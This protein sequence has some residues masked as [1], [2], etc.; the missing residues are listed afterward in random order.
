[1]Y[2]MNEKLIVLAAL[3][4]RIEKDLFEAIVEGEL[5]AELKDWQEAK[6]KD[7]T[8]EGREV[9][10]DVQIPSY[11]SYRSFTNRILI[12]GIPGS[13]P[14]VGSLYRAHE[15][16]GEVAYG[17]YLSNHALYLQALCKQLSIEIPERYQATPDHLSILIE[18]VVFLDEHTSKETVEEFIDA[19]FDWLGSYCEAL[20]Q[21]MNAEKDF[22]LRASIHFYRFLVEG[23]IEGL[24]NMKRRGCSEKKTN[25][26][27]E[28]FSTR[29]C[30]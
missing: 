1:M 24:S 20:L 18:L 7:K 28:R 23:V 29:L 12:P 6:G 30:R 8:R 16:F 3:F 9:F 4:E 2:D 26:Y 14:P 19:H 27:Q 17:G 25:D 11:E 21:R 5:M 10:A 22:T 13:L 15:A